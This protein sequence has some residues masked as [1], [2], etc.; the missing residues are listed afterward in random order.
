MSL[1]FKVKY[2]HFYTFRPDDDALLTFENS[3]KIS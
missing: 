2:V 3:V 1:E